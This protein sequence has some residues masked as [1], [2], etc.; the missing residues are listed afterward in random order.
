MVTMISFHRKGQGMSF[1]LI[2]VNAFWKALDP[3][4]TNDKKNFQRIG[5]S[6]GRYGS[7]ASFRHALS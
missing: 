1:R 2:V 4:L 6:G 5:S 3:T 7:I